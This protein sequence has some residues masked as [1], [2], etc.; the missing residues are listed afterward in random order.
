M[1]SRLIRGLAVCGL[2]LLSLVAA[3]TASAGLFPLLWNQ[4]DIG[5]AQSLPWGGEPRQER[6]GYDTSALV[7]DTEALLAADVPVIVRMETLRRAAFYAM[8]DQGLARTLLTRLVDRAVASKRADQP[9]AMALFDAGYAAALFTEVDRMTDSRIVSKVDGYAMILASID[10]RPAD[11]GLHFAAARV[12]YSQ[13]QRGGE[14]AV[15]EAAVHGAAP[16]EPLLARNLR[17]ID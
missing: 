17:L 10:L 8:R 6:R 5:T 1:S 15:H 3:R 7:A 4:L 16:R 13:G 9:D 11:A 2:V 14:T 12:R